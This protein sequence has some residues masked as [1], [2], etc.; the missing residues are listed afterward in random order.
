MQ[1]GS[2][3]SLR[4]N[5]RSHLVQDEVTIELVEKFHM[6]SPQMQAEINAIW[7]LALGRKDCLLF[8]GTVLSVSTITP[9]NI[10]VSRDSY[11]S[12]FAQTKN[13]E[14]YGDLGIRPL[15]CSGFTR[16]NDGLVF[17]RR[18]NEMFI[19]PGCWELAP[20]GTFDAQS[21][22]NN[23][24][25]NASEFLLRELSE[26]LG[27]SATNAQTGTVCGLFENSISRGIDLAVDV[28]LNLDAKEIHRRFETNTNKEYSTLE[29]VAEEALADFISQADRKF[30]F[31]SLK[32]L[33]KK[34]FL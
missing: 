22:N 31:L 14:L 10:K 29:I 6:P 4:D 27:I 2:S 21:I 32:L 7:N 25:I 18:S 8:D 26:E 19:E 5:L 17:G 16:C 34:G 30:V 24:I 3:I 12:Y 28:E 15:A 13:P 20:S 11:K 1:A 9:G 33:E 23:G